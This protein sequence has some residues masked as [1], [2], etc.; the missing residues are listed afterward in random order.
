MSSFR[1]RAWAYTSEKLG[2]VKVGGCE[3]V[4]EKYEQCVKFLD[5]AKSVHAKMEKMIK[6]ILSLSESVSLV[7]AGLP[8]L[9]TGAPSKCSRAVRKV[10]KR[11]TRAYKEG[12]ADLI[13]IFEAEVL[14]PWQTWIEEASASLTTVRKAYKHRRRGLEHYTRKCVRLSGARDLN[15]VSHPEGSM[16]LERQ[17]AKVERNL[18]KKETAQ[19]LY[20]LAMQR[21]HEIMDGIMSDDRFRKLNHFVTRITQ[22]QIELIDRQMIT[23]RGTE[24]QLKV[25]NKFN[26]RLDQYVMTKRNF[27]RQRSFSLPESP[28]SSYSPSSSSSSSLSSSFSSHAAGT[29]RNIVSPLVR[30]ESVS[31]VAP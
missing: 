29:R 25:L 5:N 2:L 15:L 22:F 12:T 17:D 11:V 28:M 16:K 8:G 4:E 24:K 14:K 18:E 1:V 3:E 7:A 30:L 26:Q 9:Y 31:T 6:Q 20:E 10:G 13:P 23:L 27:Q 21:T 19:K